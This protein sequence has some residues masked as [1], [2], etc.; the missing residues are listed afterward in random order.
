[1]FRSV[2]F[3]EPLGPTSP[4]N[5]PRR[6]ESDTPL[7]ALIGVSPIGYVFVSLSVRINSSFCMEPF[8]V[9]ISG[10]HGR[11]GTGTGATAANPHSGACQAR[12]LSRP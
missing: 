2:V 7:R 10:P 11:P 9:S 8:R 4:A 12:W 1:M 6:N 3:P 5:S